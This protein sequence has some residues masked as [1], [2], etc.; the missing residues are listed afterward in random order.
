[1][2]V[3]LV[4]TTRKTHSYDDVLYGRG[5]GVFSLCFSWDFSNC[6]WHEDDFLVDAESRLFDSGVR[7]HRSWS[8]V[9]THIQV[10]EVLY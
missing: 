3:A 5:I 8:M 6:T 7:W 1:M 4:D 9:D 2:N 10:E